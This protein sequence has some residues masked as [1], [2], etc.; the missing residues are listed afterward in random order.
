MKR[1]LMLFLTSLLVAVPRFAFAQSTAAR[2][3]GTVTD[4]SGAVVPGAG[5]SVT[6]TAT[7]WKIRATSNPEG[8]YVLYP[9]PP[10]TYNIDFEKGGFEA[11][12]IEG[13]QLYA[14]DNVARNVK[15]E[16]GTISQAV[17][18]TAAAAVLNQSPSVE[19]TV[20]EDQVETLPLNGRD[21]NQLVFLGT[22]AVDFQ[23]SGRTTGWARWP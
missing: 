1:C 4:A 16:V 20:T 15:L 12:H 22:G 9:L 5:V 2:I 19:N 7:G 6:N 11:V 17:T 8:Q 14:D 3:Q 10:G 18:V 13:L 23:V 21:Y